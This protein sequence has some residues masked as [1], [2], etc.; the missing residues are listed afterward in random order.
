MSLIQGKKLLTMMMVLLFTPIALS[1]HQYIPQQNLFLI[2]LAPAGDAKHI[3]RKIGDNFERGI[4]LQYAE[5]LKKI[6]EGQ[7]PSIAVIISRF[8]G[9]I[10][11]PLQNASFAN[12]L[13]VDLFISIHFYQTTE[14]KPKLHLYQFSYNDDFITPIA[15][16]SFYHYDQAHL[17]NKK[18][19]NTWATCIKQMCEEDQYQKLFIVQD[20]CKLPFKPLIG[21]TTPAIGIE[22]G[23]KNAPDWQQYL[24]PI[25]QSI[26]TLY[27]KLYSLP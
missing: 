3:G 24:A 2:M 17:F 10:I 18:Q 23:L 5:Q 25:A 15:G 11:S 4:T 27:R 21:V 9:D 20:I 26:H 1:R 12:R 14:T 7:C 6:V 22:I 19:T 16:L 13:Q 8:P